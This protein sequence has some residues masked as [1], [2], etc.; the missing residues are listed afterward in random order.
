[1]KFLSYSINLYR[2]ILPT[3][4]QIYTP[5]F[6]SVCTLQMK[7]WKLKKSNIACFVHVCGGDGGVS[8]LVYLKDQGAI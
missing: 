6:I 8:V 3:S 2:K 7:K 1:M 5:H 4:E